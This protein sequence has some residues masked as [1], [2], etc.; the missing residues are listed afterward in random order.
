[1]Y[2]AGAGAFLALMGI[3]MRSVTHAPEAI[4]MIVLG[5]VVAVYGVAA[6]R[7]Q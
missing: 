1:M 2:L 6:K 3:G 5:A 4:A 7:L